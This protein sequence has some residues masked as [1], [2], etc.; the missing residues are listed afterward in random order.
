MTTT[1]GKCLKTIAR[2]HYS[3]QCKKCLK[4]LH[5]DCANLTIE[6][7]NAYFKEDKQADG[8]KFYCS[9]CGVKEQNHRSLNASSTLNESV[10]SRSSIMDDIKEAMKEQIAEVIKRIETRHEES[11]AEMKLQRKELLDKIAILENEIKALKQS[12]VELIKIITEAPNLHKNESQQCLPSN[13]STKNTKAVHNSSENPK[14]NLSNTTRNITK[15]NTTIPKLKNGTDIPQKPSSAGTKTNDSKTVRGTN[16]E[17]PDTIKIYEKDNTP[18]CS[19][20]AS[21]FSLDTEVVELEK[22][23]RTTLGMKD[24]VCEELNAEVKTKTYKS[25]KITSKSITA[26]EM[27]KEDVWPEGAIVQ[28][29]KHRNKQF[30]RTCKPFNTFRRNESRYNTQSRNINPRRSRYSY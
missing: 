25:F 10:I 24:I 2:S 21:P 29:F 7:I 14:P 17:L 26:A 6:Q 15:S 18:K 1:C 4:W 22:Y 12:N 20:F 5:R 27:L 28:P 13:G 19:I 23:L 11:T 9:P 8:K 16:R 30:F 3:I